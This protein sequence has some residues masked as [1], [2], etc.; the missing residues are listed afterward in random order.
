MTQ[1]R[2]R[3]ELQFLPAA[4]DIHEPP[5]SP[6]DRTKLI[7]PLEIGTV[8]T[9]HVK[10]GQRVKKGDVLIELDTTSTAADEH[11]LGNEYSTTQ[12]ELARATALVHA[13]QTHRTPI[14]QWPT[15]ISS[16]SLAPQK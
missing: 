6:S 10:E 5:P 3:H 2:N 7:Q 1:T 16:D 12:A 9:I 14:A 13:M 4:L 8:S 11:R 15:N